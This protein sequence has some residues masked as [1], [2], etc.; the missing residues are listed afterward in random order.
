M[1]DAPTGGSDFFAAWKVEV[2]TQK[3]R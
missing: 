2:E 3:K 1:T